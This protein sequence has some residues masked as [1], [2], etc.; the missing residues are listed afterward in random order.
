MKEEKKEI[1]MDLVEEGDRRKRH[2]REDFM[3]KRI[4]RIEWNPLMVRF[5]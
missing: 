5:N 3:P 4:A 2:N 1:N